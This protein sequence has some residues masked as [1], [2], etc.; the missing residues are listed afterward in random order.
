M[1]NSEISGHIPILHYFQSIS[2]LTNYWSC[3]LTKLKSSSY[4]WKISYVH[5]HL[6]KWARWLSLQWTYA[7]IFGLVF[8]VCCTDKDHSKSTHNFVTSVDNAKSLQLWHLIDI[9][10]GTWT[11]KVWRDTGKVQVNET[12]SL[13]QRGCHGKNLLPCCI[14]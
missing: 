5:N 12:S 10:T 3:W 2:F 14:T 11:W 8:C 7:Q 13:R 9:C 1:L 6:D 4:S